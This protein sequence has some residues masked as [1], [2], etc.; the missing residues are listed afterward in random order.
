MRRLYLGLGE[1]ISRETFLRLSRSSAGAVLFPRLEW[2]CFHVEGTEIPP[3]SFHLFFPPQLKYLALYPSFRVSDIPGDRVAALVHI[4]SFL[5]NSLQELIL[6]C[7]QGR[8]PL[9]EDAV[10]SFICRHGSSLKGLNSDTPLSE[11]AIHHLMQ[12][13]T[14]RSWFAIQEPPQTL[15][16][17]IFPSL[18]NL[19]LQSAALQWLHTLTSHETD[20]IQ[21]RSTLATPHTNIRETLKFL[22]FPRNTIINSTLLSSVAK[23]WNLVGLQV[24]G[25][26]SGAEGCISRLTDDDVESLAAALPRLTNVELVKPCRHNSCKTTI[27]SLLS[28]S[29][30]CLG[31]KFLEIHFNTQTIVGDMRRLLDGGLGRDKAKCEL[32]YLPAGNSPLEVRREDAET[33][34]MGFKAIFP[35]LDSCN[36]GGEWRLVLT[37]LAGLD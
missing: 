30:H 14:L 31:L 11:A 22:D 13:P 4:I 15:P 19:Y 8:E 29:I 17:V 18:E 33:I 3:S 1:N 16:P 10:S 12:L 2:L 35:H 24:V 37:A 5:T 6:R 23:F 32:W 9:F 20:I 21:N 34:A 36:G 27:S 7:D 25:D 26:C 28:L